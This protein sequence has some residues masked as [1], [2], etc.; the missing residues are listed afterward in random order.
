MYTTGTTQILVGT[1]ATTGVMPSVASMTKIGEVYQNTC[2]I[3][4]DKPDITGH[5]EEGKSFDAIQVVDNKAPKLAFSLMNAD[6]QLLADYI[7]GS[8]ASGRWGYDGTAIV[9][10]KAFSLQTARGL[11]FDIP[12][13]SIVATLNGDMSKKGIFLVDFE[14]TPLAV[15]A[16]SP[17]YGYNGAGLTVT[18]TSLAFTAAADAVG[19]TIT[20][21]STGNLTF[22]AAPSSEDWLTVIRV[23][24]VATVKVSANTNSE[25]R[26]ANVTI[27][28]DGLTAVIQVTQAGA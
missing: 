3:T 12:N 21:T 2:K 4:Q 22:A 14:V 26:V 11:C 17:F 13:A 6:A 10:N 1:A 16:N 7:G 19:K 9:A 18:P 5:K 23:L 28:A 24:K 25:P 20:A 8:I 15:S 27:V